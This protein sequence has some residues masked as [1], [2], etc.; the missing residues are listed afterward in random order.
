MSSFFDF[1]PYMHGYKSATRDEFMQKKVF[2]H[3][4]PS[5]FWGSPSL[6]SSLGCPKA[7]LP[8]SLDR[9]PES[10]YWR[11]SCQVA[12]LPGLMSSQCNFRKKKK[13]WA[14][15][16]CFQ[17]FISPLKTTSSVDFVFFTEFIIVTCWRMSL[18]VRYP[19]LC[20]RSGYSVLLSLSVWLP[21][22]Y[23]SV[24]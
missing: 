3:L 21:S 9:S 19:V 16:P 11:F 24:I 10:F 23:I 1:G 4:W 5:A 8:N 18:F 20:T 2:L 7:P 17:S 13:K 6:F 15:V 14:P 22:K 12:L